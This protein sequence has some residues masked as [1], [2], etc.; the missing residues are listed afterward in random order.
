MEVNI[1]IGFGTLKVKYTQY[2]I[3]GLEECTFIVSYLLW[4]KIEYS[5]P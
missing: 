2:G 1:Y 5:V 4:D 3:C